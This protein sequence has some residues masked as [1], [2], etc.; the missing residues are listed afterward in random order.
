VSFPSTTAAK[1]YPAAGP[2]PLSPPLSWRVGLWLM[3][4][5]GV[6]GCSLGEAQT[7][8]SLLRQDGPGST[9]DADTIDDKHGA[10]FIDVDHT[11]SGSAIS[12]GILAEARVAASVTRDAELFQTL[13]DHD[14]AGSGLD[15]DLLDGLE[16]SHFSLLDHIHSGGEF[17]SGV[18]DLNR[19]DTSLSNDKGITLTNDIF[20]RLLQDEAARDLTT[21]GLEAATLDEKDSN[22]FSRAAHVHSGAEL[23][24]GVVA[25]GFL[26]LD[27]ITTI[28]DIMPALLAAK[29]D[30]TLLHAD[31][32]KDGSDVRDAAYFSPQSH[33]HD[34]SEISTGSTVIADEFIHPSLRRLRQKVAIVA[35]N[36]TDVRGFYLTPAQ[37]IK[38]LA[39]WCGTPSATNP[40]TMQLMP[41]TFDLGSSTLSLDHSYL[42]LQG[43]GRDLT[44]LT[45]TN[46]QAVV[47]LAGT[48]DHNTLSQLTLENTSIGAAI[49]I[50]QGAQSPKLKELSLK[51][52]GTVAVDDNGSTD[53]ELR[54]S[55][56]LLNTTT[57]ANA[58]HF[59]AATRARLFSTTIRVNISGTAFVNALRGILFEGNGH[60]LEL[61]DC[62][63][64]VDDEHESSVNS[65]GIKMSPNP[66]ANFA[67]LS[68]FILEDSHV[69]VLSDKTGTNV[70]ALTLVSG[71]TSRIQRSEISAQS[72]GAG[73]P[74]T[75]LLIETG[76]GDV[77]IR[78]S[79]LVAT[80]SGTKTPIKT[81][82]T[83][84]YVASSLVS[85]TAATEGTGSYVCIGAYGESFTFLDTNCQ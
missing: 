46:T 83:I 63:L 15:A 47:I 24:S 50:A 74:V 64:V 6:G 69:T 33:S 70:T 54:D 45:S 57:D 3:A 39:I 18:V 66:G 34:G 26:P 81:T 62:Q 2:R 85:G 37:A 51:A 58:L 73:N 60:S 68:T 32:L 21:V 9:F 13:L 82:D 84:A 27:E 71:A 5:M 20:N 35:Q 10:D 78:S 79:R 22:S 31:L 41:G 72:K 42:H 4:G 52:A 8:K 80:S 43:S 19:L 17:I 38:D 1:W 55:L 14:G 48:A 40:C 76:A 49:Q 30:G 67:D 11:H 65:E 77:K 7:V 28:S 61:Q 56:V 25:A 53:L 44:R 16:S 12:T 23:T 59:N 36:G 29:G 75:G